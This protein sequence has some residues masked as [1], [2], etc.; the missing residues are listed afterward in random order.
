MLRFRSLPESSRRD[1]LKFAAAGASFASLSGW[2]DVLAARSRADGLAGRHKSCILLWMEGGASHKDTFDLKPGTPDGGEFRPIATS[3]PGLEISEHLPKLARQMHHAAVLRGMSTSQGAHGPARYFMH[4]GYREGSGGLVHPSLGSI[5]SSELGSR[6]PEFP[7]PNFVSVGG[8]NGYGAGFLGVRHQP[9]IVESP[10]RGVENLS[11][12]VGATRSEK[13]LG[14]LDELERGFLRTGRTPL[15]DDHNTT[16]ERTRLLMQSREAKAFDLASEPAASRAAYGDGEFAQGCLLA[17]RLVEVG[18]P[19]VEVFSPGWDTHQ[20]NF[21][22]VRKLSGQIDTPIAALIADLEA[23]GM[24]DST[25]VI[26]MGEFGRTPKIT[27]KAGEAGRGHY[28][29]AW[30]TVLFGGGIPGGQVLGKTDKE[31][32]EILE[33]PVSALDFLA[34]VCTLLGIDHTKQNPTP[35]GRPIRIVDQG[36]RPIRELIG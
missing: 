24:L 25:L 17:R 11:T 2:L 4:T 13:R 26:W 5:V 8:K 27:S 21:N 33:R 18:V 35:I 34:T 6:T 29:R 1:F 32:A 3:V 31:G 16:Y 9:L 22:R 7:L 23:R 28:P 20:D 19:F 12:P 30:S 15:G 10:S 36:A 14:L